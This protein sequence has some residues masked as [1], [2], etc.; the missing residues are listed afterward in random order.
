MN[1]PNFKF[2]NE[3]ACV[4]RKLRIDTILNKDDEMVYH[5]TSP[6]GLKGIITNQTL[7][8]TD[9]YF[10]NDYSE[11]T[12]VLDLCAKNINKISPDVKEF[13]KELKKQLKKTRNNLNIGFFRA[14]QCSFSIDSDS[15]CLWNYYTKGNNINGYN[16]CFDAKNLCKNFDLKPFSKNGNTP[17]PLAGRV[18]YDED[19]QLKMDKKLVNEFWQVLKKYY[20]K[21]NKAAAGDE[22]KE[23]IEFITEK[24][25]VLGI[26]FKKK[27]F[28]IE[29]EYRI[30]FNLFEKKNG[31]FGAINMD[32]G[33][34]EKKTEF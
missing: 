16:L 11:V 2:V 1:S 21:E 27:C 8:F 31:D 28:E 22:I 17:Q 26:F 24:L 14:F 20:D 6:E 9:R 30:C 12:Y 32:K 19:E 23:A 5:Y 34:F 7:R 25:L 3:L 15:L 18:I 29:H 33:Y 10:L 13:K 4:Y